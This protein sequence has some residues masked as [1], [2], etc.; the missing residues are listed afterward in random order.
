MS[1]GATADMADA[2]AGIPEREAY[3]L[4]ALPSTMRAAVD[5]VLGTVQCPPALA[6]MSALAVLSTAA[7][8]HVDVAR[9]E[10]L[11]GP[12]SL[13]LLAIAES[14]ERKTAVDRL[15]A[16]V[17]HEYERD[18]LRAA[19]PAITQ[20]EAAQTVWQAT[21]D[22]LRAAIKSAA[23]G[24]RRKATRSIPELQAELTAHT[25]TR[26]EPVRVPTML[27]TDATSE[28]LAW[29]L[30][31]DWPSGAVI[32][33]EGGLVLGGHAMQ[34]ETIVRTLALHNALW[35]GADHRITRRQ[36]GASYTLAG[37][38]FT[39][40]LQVQPATIDDFLA[41]HGTLARGIGWLARCL[42]AA[43]ESTQGTR[44]YRAPAPGYPALEFYH[45]RIRAILAEPLP[46]D[47]DR[48]A[49]AVLWLRGAAR[50]RWIACH[51]E[52]ERNLA[53]G[54]ELAGIRDSGAKAAEQVARLA[55]LVARYEQRGEVSADDVDR[56][57]AIVA[58]HL[59][60]T[61]RLFAGAA[62][63]RRRS[64]SETLCAWV[65]RQPEPPTRRDAQNGGPI[66]DGVSLDAAMAEAEAAGRLS[67][68]ADGTMMVNV[69]GAR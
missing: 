5:E 58:W 51:N 48:L 22:G 34:R 65:A 11:A 12:T 30:H 9:D 37:R 2:L 64:Q 68:G 28:G 18:A 45:D 27:Q 14:G 33:S 41:Q 32:T 47:G 6:A 43:P 57:D 44:M 40:W 61:R 20:H 63:A 66:R 29:A 53:R 26:P 13:N 60:E 38:R 10:R 42:I 16:R 54:G 35:D 17:L 46:M 4:D 8:A 49:P 62:N 67:I 23:A 39:L 19:G 24:G 36:A 7:Q 55:A 69:D 3:P 21:H 31:T 59:D 15:C 52:Y 50:E 1:G 25:A 56:A